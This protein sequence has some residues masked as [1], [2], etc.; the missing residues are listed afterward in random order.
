MAVNEVIYNGQTLINLKNDTVTPE[1]L[2]KGT[3]AHDAS[4]KEI[5]GKMPI[6]T[7]LYTEQS[8]T[9]E[10]KAQ[11]RENIGVDEEYKAN[12]VQA[13]I[14]S[15]GGNPVFGYVDENNNI[16]LSGNVA[17]GTYSVKYEMEDGS[18]VDIGS[19]VLA[20]EEPDVPTYTNFA[21]PTST[22]WKVGYRL[23]TTIDQVTALTGG[24]ATNYISIQT[25]DIV[26]V[27]GINFTNTNNRQAFNGS[28]GGICKAEALKNTY[29]SY[30]SDVSYDSNN[31]KFTVACDSTL[32]RFSGL[33]TGTSEDVVIKITR[34]GVLL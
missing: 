10:Q 5:T 17:D 23:T 28:F 26:E 19:L 16:V 14:E 24:V 11:A 3:T 31:L 15:L 29:S 1:T 32:A 33:V 34:N 4:G 6:E 2:A 22:D 9:D 7:I 12:L 27:S 20:E 30:F 21:D 18:T 13:V 25:G 8:L